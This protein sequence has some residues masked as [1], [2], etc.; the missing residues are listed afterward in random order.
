MALTSELDAPLVRVEPPSHSAI[1]SSFPVLPLAL[2]FG[3]V[4]ATALWGAALTAMGAKIRLNAAPLFGRLDLHLSPLLLLPAAVAAAAIAWGGRLAATLGWRNLLLA[5]SAASALWG[6]TLASA[7]GWHALVAPLLDRHDYLAVLPDIGSPASFLSD[8]TRS[9][10][11]F[12]LHVQGHPP[13]FVLLLSTLRTLG[14]AVAPIAAALTIAVG[15]STAAAVLITVRV[16]AGEQRARACAPFLC[17]APAAIWV[18]TSADGFYMGVAAW[19]IALLALAVERNGS[20]SDALA[21]AAGVTLGAA[22][23]MSYGVAALG[24]VIV[25]IT[26]L[27][28]RIRPLVLAGLGVATVA[29]MFFIFGFWW[30][31]GLV[32][33]TGRYALGVSGSRPY[34]YFFFSNLG[35]LALAL[36]PAIAIGLARLRD[37]RLWAIVG[38]ACLAVTVANLTGLSKGEVERI[39]LPY[40]PWLLIASAAIPLAFRRS[41]LTMQV[42]AALVLQ[43]VVVTPW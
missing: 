20:V 29:G 31:D 28:P 6:V 37:R 33:T 12:P 42:A 27:R 23:Y 43:A 14:I 4:A 21:L 5:A 19:A 13:G 1:D 39:W 3:L 22:L 17:F 2:W 11:A 32:A 35:A 15:A 41:A 25:T 18:V 30:F 7:D 40:I 10:P 24:G 38:A 9:L 26:A 36:G 34:E 8:F 16:V